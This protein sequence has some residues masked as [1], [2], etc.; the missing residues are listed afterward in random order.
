MG[1]RNGSF[2]GT[3]DKW[4]YNNLKVKKILIQDECSTSKIVCTWH[5]LYALL[6]KIIMHWT[7]LG[8]SKLLYLPCNLSSPEYFGLSH[9]AN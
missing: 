5:V 4:C 1:T 6:D 7:K 9:I 2:A 8:T 3:N